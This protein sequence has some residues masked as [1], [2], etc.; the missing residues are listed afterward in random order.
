MMERKQKP[1]KAAA[2]HWQFGPIDAGK[3]NLYNKNQQIAE[4]RSN[5]WNPPDANLIR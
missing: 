1:Q 2:N 4:R 3:G 5:I